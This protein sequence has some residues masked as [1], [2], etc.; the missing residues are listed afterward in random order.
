MLLQPARKP[1]FCTVRD[2]NMRWLTWFRRTRS[3]QAPDP[4]DSAAVGEYLRA[5]G[6][7]TLDGLAQFDESHDDALPDDSIGD[8]ATVSDVQSKCCA[9]G[10]TSGDR[11]AGTDPVTFRDLGPDVETD[12]RAEHAPASSSVSKQCDVGEVPDNKDH[13]GENLRRTPVAGDDQEASSPEG[14]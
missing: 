14:P 10:E 12:A 3:S 13:A 4:A 8:R 5:I 1:F 6:A 9:A 7:V 11:A 2:P